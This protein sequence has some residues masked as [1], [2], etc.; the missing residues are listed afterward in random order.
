M[1]TGRM[2]LFDIFPQ[3]GNGRFPVKISIDEPLKVH[4]RCTKNHANPLVLKI[5]KE[6]SSAWTHIPMI[7]CNNNLWFAEYFFTELGMYRYAIEIDSTDHY[8]Y[9]I[10][11]PIWVESSRTRYSTWYQRFPRSCSNIPHKYATFKEFKKEIKRIASMGFDTIYIP[12]IHPIG[13][14]NRKGKNGTLFPNKDDVGSVWAVGNQSGGHKAIDPRYGSLDDFSELVTY[15]K[16]L[17]V[18]IAFDVTFH[19][20]P[21]H[22]YITNH[23]EWFLK[24]S[25]GRFLY[26]QD[27]NVDYHD[28]IPFD[29]NCCNKQ[30]LWDELKSIVEFWVELGISVFRIDNPHTKPILFW[31]WLLYQIKLV[32]PEVIFLSEALTDPDRMHNLAKAGM[33]QSYDYFQWKTNK[34]EIESY[35]SE[36]YSKSISS[37]FRPVLWTNTPQNLPLYLQHRD[38]NAFLIRFILAGTLGASYGIYGPPFEYCMNEPLANNSVE[39]KD[40]EQFEIPDWNIIKQYPISD[41]IQKLNLIRLQNCALQNN[42]SLKFHNTDNANVIAY[43]KHT[44]DFMN[45]IIVI[46]NLTPEIAQN[47]FVYLDA[48]AIKLT[49]YNN[50]SV[51][52]LL[53]E[54]S[55]SWNNSKNY[56][57]FSPDKY[58]AHVLLVAR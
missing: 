16:N 21:D 57:E 50:F 5:R 34:A 13:I 12:P 54:N 9:P 41:I 10:E 36:I 17:G 1:D 28:V 55:Y 56:F 15:S 24:D 38:K 25:D 35:Y 11:I 20:S 14:A 37:Y 47:G 29:F 44:V 27:G 46:V 39:Y 52:D 22:P 42:W 8:C 58:I 51:H 26:V 30:A 23:P 33:S 32:H 40:S 6:Q 7:P 48:V 53:Y 18:E 43:S 49:D 3:I 4:A 2:V 45:T 19:C 31:E